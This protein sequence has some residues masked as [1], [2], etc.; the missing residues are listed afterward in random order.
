MLLVESL[1][2][3]SELDTGMIPEHSTTTA[4]EVSL[5]S[6]SFAV[7]STPVS[8]LSLLPL[9]KPVIPDELF[10]LPSNRCFGESYSFTWDLPS[11]SVSLAL[12]MPKD[13]LVV[14]PEHFNRP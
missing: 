9:Q 13:S 14:H 12:P 1:E 2:R 3:L 6:L 10:H 11:S 8:N 4:S 5:P 7:P